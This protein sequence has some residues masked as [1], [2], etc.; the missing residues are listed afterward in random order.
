MNP[1]I[2]VNAGSIDWLARWREMYD[3]ERAQGEAATDPAFRRQSDCW[4]GRAERFAATSRRIEQPD[5][6]MQLLAPRLQPTDRVLDVGAGT[7][8]YVPFLA[9][10]VAKVIAVE[11]S[12]A[13]RTEL[14]LT[15]DREQVTNV[16]VCPEN[17][18]LR[19]P[20]QAEVVLSAHVV[21]G[22]R[23]I[24]PFLTA[25]DAAATRLCVLFLGLKH[26]TAVL[27]PFWERVHGEPRLPLPAAL[28]TL[29]A[30]HQLGLPANLE[31]V[32]AGRPFRFAGIEEALEELQVRLR[33]G[34]DPQWEATLR[35]AIADLLVMTPEGALAPRHAPSHAAVIWW[36]PTS[37]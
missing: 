23:E 10:H 27:A 3:A 20:I 26:P 32:P 25:L 2:R 16:Q 22:V 8:R 18:P 37:R 28:E 33:L 36:T 12:P 24:G 6:F 1:F 14:E 9:Q 29:A 30:C 35:Q 5:A 15:L 7:G 31:L 11:P 21:Y 19:E 4:T 17:W 13:M 34:P